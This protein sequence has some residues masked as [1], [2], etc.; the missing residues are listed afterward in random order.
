MTPVGFIALQVHA[1]GNAAD[2]G[3]TVSWKDIRICTTDV[4]R[5]QTPEAQAAPEVNLIANTIS[6]NVKQKKD[7]RYYGMARLLTDGEELNFLLSLAKRME[8]G[9]WYS[10]SDEERRCRIS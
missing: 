10:E 3:K 8:D 2:E 7:G 9:R 4:E 1:I 5:Y 6:P